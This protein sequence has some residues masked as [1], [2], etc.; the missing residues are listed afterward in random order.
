MLRITID[1]PSLSH[2]STS[3][4]CYP[5]PKNRCVKIKILSLTIPSNIGILQT[6]YYII[7]NIFI[8]DNISI[9]S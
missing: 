8:Y 7:G 1:N 4:V 5:T 2:L 3:V 9:I 6:I